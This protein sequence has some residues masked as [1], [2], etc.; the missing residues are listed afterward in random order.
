MSH[1]HTQT[2]SE[3]E[4]ERETMFFALQRLEKLRA[5]SHHG[6]ARP[7]YGTWGFSLSHNEVEDNLRYPIIA[8]M[9]INVTTLPHRTLMKGYLNPT[10]DKEK[11]FT[12]LVSRART[13]MTENVIGEDTVF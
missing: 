2:H 9:F 4:R 3:R 8:E 5:T 10:T 1:I 13:V 6:R 12:N 7:L 11:K